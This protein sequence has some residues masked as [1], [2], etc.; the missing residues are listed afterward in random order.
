[1][2]ADRTKVFVTLNFLRLHARAKRAVR[3]SYSTTFVDSAVTVQRA[4]IVTTY[5]SNLPT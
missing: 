4:P 5:V 1:M 2:C 3:S